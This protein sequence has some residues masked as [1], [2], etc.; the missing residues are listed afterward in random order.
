MESRETCPQ[1]SLWE[2]RNIPGTCMQ[3]PRARWMEIVADR[4]PLEKMISARAATTGD[5]SRTFCLRLHF[6]SM[7]TGSPGVNPQCRPTAAQWPSYCWNSRLL[8]WTYYRRESS[9][10]AAFSDPKPSFVIRCNV[11]NKCLTADEGYSFDRIRVVIYPY[12]R[13]IPA[14]DHEIDF[15][16]NCLGHRSLRIWYRD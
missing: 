11:W 1:E 5:A 14:R 16:L 15:S 2:L 7:K 8:S 3:H 12:H 9:R 4:K 10:I 6:E 13:Q